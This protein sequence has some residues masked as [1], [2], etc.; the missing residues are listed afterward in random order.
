ML[1]FWCPI[2]A[3]GTVVIDRPYLFEPLAAALPKSMIHITTQ[4]R[5]G[6]HPQEYDR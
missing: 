5:L 6:A 4:S 1:Y 3:A 2:V